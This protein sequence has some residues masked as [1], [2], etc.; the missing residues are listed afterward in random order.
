MYL[1]SSDK[2]R[3]ADALAIN[4]MKIPSTL[5]MT[6]A[7]SCLVD[8]ALEMLLEGKR[9]CI[10]CG[11]GNNGGDGV[12][13]A[14]MLI[15]KGVAV[16]AWLIGSR[17][18][19]TA[20]T[21]EM[22][23]RLNEYG[24]LLSDFCDN[25]VLPPDCGLIIDAMFGIGLNSPLRGMG[26][27]A[28]K[29]INSSGVPVLAADI[30][31]GVS[32]DTGAVL[33]EAVKADVTVTFSMAKPGHFVEPGCV[34]SGEIRV[35]DI[36]IPADIL[37]DAAENI[38]VIDKIVLPKRE[39]LTHKYSYGRLLL[40]GGS[41]G[42]TG[43]ISLC[44]K[45]AVRGGAGVVFVGVPGNIYEV[46][47]VKNDEAVVFPVV[48]DKY[49]RFCT[50][51]IPEALA[52]FSSAA[53]AVVGPGL[54]RSDDLTEFVSAIISSA[55]CP[56]LLDADALF[57]VGQRPEML[58]K[59]NAPLILT[60][61]EGEFKALGGI[62]TGDRL[63]D[64]ADFAKKY[65]CILVLKGHHSIAAFPDGET[66]ICPYG[67]PGMAKGGCGDVL[68]GIMGSL[69]CQMPVKEAVKAALYIHARTGDLCAE[70]FGE[71][72][73]TPSDMINCIWE[74]TKQLTAR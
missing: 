32:A 5:L 56:V 4:E 18:K 45:A 22:E 16:S 3:R 36:G 30:A 47:A 26:L 50:D 57:A 40:L 43:A 7:A 71:Y 27:A 8:A 65:G 38:S 58:H 64:A 61:H 12:A 69:L 25:T 23:R 63:K 20:D 41:V 37:T 19:M 24:G 73:M 60:P 21:R 14:Y 52:R 44:A 48:S 15:R 10:F 42:Y 72:S 2:M 74:T 62:L 46:T 67:N 35:C 66:A 34:H 53:A 29:L 55:K 54:S 49:G 33:G 13:A 6:N 39:K 11:G 51:S 70:K 31:S 9:V 28:A 1:S 17:D 68:A 59:A